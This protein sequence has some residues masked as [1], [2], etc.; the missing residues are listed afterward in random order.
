[1]KFF[2]IITLFLCVTVQA[3]NKCILP[4]TFKACNDIS[5]DF[6]EKKIN[7]K[8]FCFKCD[9][10]FGL[11]KKSVICDDQNFSH[12]EIYRGTKNFCRLSL[13]KL[14]IQA[15]TNSTKE[16]CKKVRFHKKKNE[17]GNRG[18]HICSIK[19]NKCSMSK[20]GT[21]LAKSLA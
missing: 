3:E 1:M 6:K 14:F 17:I 13:K 20:V 5:A 12:G 7:D 19:K 2:L 10:Q 15:C 21:K 11:P 18:R 9:Q 8:T 4:S 16:D